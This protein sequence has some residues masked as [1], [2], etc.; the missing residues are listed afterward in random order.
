LKSE[1]I[2]PRKGTIVTTPYRLHK[3]QITDYKFITALTIDADGHHVSISG[4]NGSGKT[5]TVDAIYEALR[6]SS[7]KETPE[8]I[9]HGAKAAEIALDLGQVMVVRRITPSG[10][11]LTV[12]AADGSDIKQP[13]QL[14]NSLLGEYSLDPVAF[15]TRRPQDQV[16]DILAVCGVK[17]PVAAVE[18]ICGEKH[19]VIGT[20]SA[21]AY[22]A[23][24]SADNTGLYYN[25]RRDQGRDVDAKKSAVAEVEAKVTAAGGR[26]TDKDQAAT[27]TELLQQLDGLQKQQSDRRDLWTAVKE[28]DRQVGE[29][30][31]AVDVL[32]AKYE[33]IDEEIT[34]IDNEI[35]KLQQRKTALAADRT[36]IES[37]IESKLAGVD[38]CDTSLAAAK[39]AHAAAADPAESIRVVRE[40]VQNVEVKNKALQTRQAL[41]N[42]ADQFI[43]EHRKS[44][45][46]HQALDSKLEH[47]RDLRI[48]LLDGVSL[49]IDGLSLS[50][51]DLHLN[52][53]PYRQASHAERLRVACAV[54]MKQNPALKLLRVDDGEHL[55]KNS[56]ALLLELADANDWQVIITAVSSTDTELKIEIEDAK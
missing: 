13:Q 21:D 8:P 46:K 51:G 48:H 49:G 54:A 31:I 2:L 55:D 56:R 18:K 20:E 33:R 47:L 10:S 7:S 25:R 17:P 50:D 4:P 52:G 44:V 22:L 3:L 26:I 35:I 15:L 19:P 29:A 43:E 32:R 42:T 30:Q 14:L 23:R 37:N 45:E 5:S 28:A 6:G 24:L 9:R 27:A 39:A 11:R 53:I 40:R 38:A 34:A 16:D 1:T 41:S 36:G 12:T